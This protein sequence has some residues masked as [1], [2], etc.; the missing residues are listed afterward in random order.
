MTTVLFISEWS[1]PDAWREALAQHVPDLDFRI[2]PDAGNPGDVEFALAWQA[3][4]R[5]YDAFPNL[6]AIISLG[7]GVDHLFRDPDIPQTMPLARV[8]DPTLTRMM[9]DYVL[10]A[11]LR[12]HRDFDVYERAQAQKRWSGPRATPASRRTIGIL[13][14][15]ELGT[16]VAT[17]LAG[18]GFAVRGWS[19]SPRQLSGIDHFTGPGLQGFLSETEI[20]VNLLPLTAATKNILNRET[21]SWLPKGACFVNVGRGAHVDEA[22]LVEQLD[23]GH[24][25]GATLDAFRVEPLPDG[26]P[27]WTHP[28][29]LVTPHVASFTDPISAAPA[30]AENFL[31]AR[32]G[33]PLRH[34]VTRAQSV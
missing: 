6:R 19:R 23:R 25:R 12:Y 22:A 33:E 21:L 11:V 18:H 1:D 10:A 30:I 3:P 29:V 32:R 17:M 15:G 16:A 24:I 26:H 7:A 31:R 2:W 5:F 20:L 34:A 4:L 8:V 28:R 14:M 13:G 9:C 27:F